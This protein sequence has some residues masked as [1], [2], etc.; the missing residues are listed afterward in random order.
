MN[1]NCENSSITISKYMLH[2][3][4]MDPLKSILTHGSGYLDKSVFW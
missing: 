3:T 1:E 2:M 4:G